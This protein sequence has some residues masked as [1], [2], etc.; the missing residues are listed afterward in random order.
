MTENFIKIEYRFTEGYFGEAM[1]A[2][3][4]N[5]MIS[6]KLLDY[7]L[8]VSILSIFANLLLRME[9]RERYI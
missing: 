5:I 1:S 2:V 6:R 4:W 8:M 3:Y 9:Q 7:T